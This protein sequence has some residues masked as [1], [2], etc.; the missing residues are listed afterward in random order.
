[1][2]R[3]G[4]RNQQPFWYAMYAGTVEDYDEYGNQIGAHAQ[5]TAPIEGSG[6]LSPAKGAVLARQFGNDDDYDNILVV[7][8]RDTP[9]DENT[10]LWIGVNPNS[11]MLCMEDG[12]QIVTNLYKPVGGVSTPPGEGELYY[13][14]WNYVVRRV[15]R[16]L[17]PFGSTEIAIS[18]V[19][20]S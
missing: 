5:Y 7:S 16:G 20:V 6:N 17:P 3:L 4:F 15:A 13:T 14:K 2:S 9:I 18:R 10:V 11:V 19:N 1:M 12:D 8:D